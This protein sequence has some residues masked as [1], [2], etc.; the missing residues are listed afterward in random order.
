[1]DF[2]VRDNQ[3]FS[4]SPK[5]VTLCTFLECLVSAPRGATGAEV[6]SEIKSAKINKRTSFQHSIDDQQSP[7]NATSCCVFLRG[8]F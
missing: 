8:S 6:T 2:I 4:H 7:F 5:D 1:M 3:S